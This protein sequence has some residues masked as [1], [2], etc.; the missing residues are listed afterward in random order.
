MTAADQADDGRGTRDRR[1]GEIA[2]A[3]AAFVACL[4]IGPGRSLAA[5]EARSLT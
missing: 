5:R 2:P 1:L 3:F 4:D